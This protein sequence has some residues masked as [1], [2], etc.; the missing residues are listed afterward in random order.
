MATFRLKNTGAKPLKIT[1]VVP[2]CGCTKTAL[3]QMEAPPGGWLEL[4]VEF[5]KS[6]AGYFNKDV[7]V[8]ANVENSP[9]ILTFSGTVPF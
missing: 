5:D 8:Y 3:S 9:L 1:P 2:D 7:K 4:S 6:S